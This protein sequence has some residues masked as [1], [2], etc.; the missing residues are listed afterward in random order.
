MTMRTDGAV[1]PRATAG[2]LAQVLLRP[3]SVALLGVSNDASKTSG[4]PLPFLRR[5]GFRGTV[6]PINARHAQVQGERAWPTLEALP[7]V[8]EHVFVLTPTEGVVSAV[9]SCAKLGVKLVTILAGGFAETGDIGIAREIEL[10][11]LARA[12][13]L[14]ILG[15]SSLGVVSPAN[16]LALTANAAFAEPEL[17][18]GR[19]FVASH[20][21]SMIGALV[22]RGKARGLGFAG[23]VSVGNEVD[24]SLG[25]ICQATLDDPAITSYLL[26]L[27]SL[28]HGHRLRSFALEA[29]RRGKPIVALKLGR[30]EGAAAMAMTHTGALAGEDDVADAFLRDLGIARVHTLDGLL[31][32]APLA[33]RVPFP[34]APGCRGRVGV[35]TTTGGGAAM[36]VDQLGVR[37]IAVE[38]ASPATVQRL[39]S[40]RI[41]GSAGRV[42]DLTLAGTRYAVMKEAL[43]ILL[44]APEFDLVVAVVGSS[45]RFNPDL[46]VEPIVHSASHTKPLVA[47]LLPDAPQALARLTAEAVPCFRTPE[48]CADA[49]AAV[50]S[51]REP[52]GITAVPQSVSATG[53]ATL[54]EDLAY[55]VLATLG[56]AHLPT[57]TLPVGAELSTLPFAFP[58]VAKVCSPDIPHK[59]EVGGVIL[60]IADAQALAAARVTLGEN[61]RSRAPGVTLDRVLIQPMCNGLAQVLVGYRVDADAGPIVL[62]AAGGV[63]AEVIQERSIRLAP[64]DLETAR[65][66]IG[67]IRALRP[68]TG[69][70]G[71]PRGDLDALA[72]AVVSLSSLALKADLGIVE[73]EINPMMVLPEGEGA[74]AADALIVRAQ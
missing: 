18:C 20:S 47:M 24:L 34:G 26:F 6:Y 33:L 45:A 22:S 48:S 28:R 56:V 57:I 50:L 36:V 49:I 42:V 16:G 14:R 44:D 46:A 19:I 10:A 60:G 72:R 53:R 62:V 54:P 64:V 27:E 61:V 31:E 39:H 21:G 51:R 58:V 17:P 2:I 35:V 63:W 1:P 74:W 30:S 5:A 25:E 37:G 52:R 29:A 13:G 3:T 68:L 55:E 11:S 40:A 7:E 12:S 4:R 69:L 59:T 38:P 67:E 41:P 71:Q 9:Q 23:L 65:E 43:G 8:P 32:A 73:A 66:M 70:R 15:P